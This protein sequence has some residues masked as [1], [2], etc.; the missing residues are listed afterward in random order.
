[1]IGRIVLPGPA[2]TEVPAN[3]II[4]VPQMFL[5]IRDVAIF[6]F[7]VISNRKDLIKDNNVF[8]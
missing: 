3:D 7:I 4:A 5:I 8:N 1:V 2:K 6:V